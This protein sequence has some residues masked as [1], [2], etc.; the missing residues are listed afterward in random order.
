MALLTIREKRL[1]RAEFKTFEEYC[2]ARWGLQNERARLL[3]RG[4]EAVDNIAATPTIV[5]VL[6]ANEAQVRPLIA[7][8]PDQQRAAWQTVVETAPNGK[9]TGALVEQVAQQFKAD[10]QRRP[11]GVRSA[12]EGG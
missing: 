7:L 3:M 1:Y 4:A 10:Q 11:A 5:G 12:S 2:Q 9:I 6:P 8:T